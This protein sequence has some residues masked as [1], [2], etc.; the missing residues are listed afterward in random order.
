VI[1]NIT[2]IHP[3]K[4][5]N[6]RVFPDGSTPNPTNTSN[7]NYITNVDKAVLAVVQL[8][9]NGRIDLYSDGATVNVAADVFGYLDSTATAASNCNYAGCSATNAVLQTPIRI[10]DTR[11]DSHHVGTVTGPLDSNKSY[12][13]QVGGQGGV[14]NDA[15]A[16]LISLTAIHPGGNG[17]GNLRV[18]PSD[19]SVPNV[20]TINYIGSSDIANFA[21]IRLPKSGTLSLYSDGV[22]TNAAVD[23]LGFIPAGS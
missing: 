13:F 6:L 4:A 17:V 5:G 9:A 20:S 12:T 19:V 1:L 18:F 3:S 7:I 23:V 10:L 16:V 15:Q 11:T 22:P 8:P 14:P 2:A 21:I